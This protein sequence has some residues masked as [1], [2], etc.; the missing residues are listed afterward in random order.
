MNPRPK[1]IRRES[2]EK[3]SKNS[4][5]LLKE[6]VWISMQCLIFIKNPG[7]M[8]GRS[9]NTG[10]AS[11]SPPHRA[12]VK[13]WLSNRQF[14][15]LWIIA[16]PNLPKMIIPVVY[17]GFAPQYSGGTAPALHRTSL[18]SPVGHLSRYEVVKQTQITDRIVAQVFQPVN[19][20]LSFSS[21]LMRDYS[22]T[23]TTTPVM[24]LYSG[25]HRKL[26]RS[27]DNETGFRSWR[28]DGFQ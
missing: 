3:A 6:T 5:P 15:W 9:S 8:P 26:C 1:L 18:L 22:L 2:R 27:R 28:L 14:S 13:R 11:K 20:M 10:A 19:R 12:W 25:T 7:K 4:L 17:D 23:F 24:I 21:T 16:R